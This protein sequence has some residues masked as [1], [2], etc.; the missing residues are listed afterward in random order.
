MPN[1]GARFPRPSAVE[2][3]W[4]GR[5]T[6]PYIFWKIVSVHI[7]VFKKKIV[8]ALA[9]FSNPSVLKNIRNLKRKLFRS[10]TVKKSRKLL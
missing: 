1:V 7:P 6:R 5:G 9:S 8:P 10:V 4:G 3:G 2:W